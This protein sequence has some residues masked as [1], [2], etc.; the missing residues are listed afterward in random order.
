M[1]AEVIARMDDVR[2]QRLEYEYNVMMA[3]R[4][5]ALEHASSKLLKMVFRKHPE[6]DICGLNTSDLALQDEFRTLMSAPADV[7]VDSSAFLMLKDQIEEIVERWRI[8]FC[9]SPVSQ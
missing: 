7:H 5:E 6:L 9:L 3:E 1:R 8:T 2:A 4:W